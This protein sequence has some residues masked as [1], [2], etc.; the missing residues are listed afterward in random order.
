MSVTDKSIETERRQRVA[1][2]EG[3]NGEVTA[4]EDRVSFCGTKMFSDQTVR[5]AQL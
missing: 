3:G 4:K 5:V 1:W 2:A